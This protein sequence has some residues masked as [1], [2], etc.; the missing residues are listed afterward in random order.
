MRLGTLPVVGSQRGPV[1][2]DAHAFRPDEASP[3]LSCGGQAS[4]R[5]PRVLGAAYP[6]EVRIRRDHGVV[7]ID[8]HDL[9]P[10]VPSI[11]SDPVR[12]KHLEVRIVLRSPFLRDPLDTLPHCY[13]ENT[14]PLRPATLPDSVL[15]KATLPYLRPDY[16]DARFGL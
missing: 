7:R 1:L 6:V 4:V 16:D 13:L 3:L 11:L 2:L 9:E 5:A 15:S 10:L 8:H 14:L 12:C